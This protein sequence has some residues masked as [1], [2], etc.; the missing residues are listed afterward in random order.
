MFPRRLGR[1]RHRRRRCLPSFS[2][3]IRP[4]VLRNC[5][6][7][8]SSTS[9]SGTIG[10][11]KSAQQRNRLNNTHTHIHTRHACARA[12]Q[13]INAT[14]ETHRRLAN[15]ANRRKRKKNVTGRWCNGCPF[16]LVKHGNCLGRF[17]I[18]QRRRRDARSPPLPLLLIVP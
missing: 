9:N 6:K 16:W 2:F 10:S 5:I 14:H 3:P 13:D 8:S 12:R 1:R 18:R 15:R 7:A 11:W 4:C 17:D